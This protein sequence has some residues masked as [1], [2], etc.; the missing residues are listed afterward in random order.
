MKILQLWRNCTHVVYEGDW[1][2]LLN[3]PFLFGLF[4]F[5]LSLLCSVLSWKEHLLLINFVDRT[6]PLKPESLWM[7]VIRGRE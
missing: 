5:S 4:S 6:G 3:C 1:N 2:N 7:R